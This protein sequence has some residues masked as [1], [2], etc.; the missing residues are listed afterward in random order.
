MTNSRDSRQLGWISRIDAQALD[1]QL[2]D[3]I[4]KLN[5]Y[6]VHRFLFPATTNPGPAQALRPVPDCSTSCHA[7]APCVYRAGGA[8][9][10][11]SGS[12][13]WPG[14]P[15]AK[16]PLTWLPLAQAGPHAIAAADPLPDD[17]RQV[18]EDIS[19]TSRPV[20]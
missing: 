17:L 10:E 7:S 9:C 5:A 13:P 8:A 20:H 14:V 18:L 2:H 3:A 4:L 1:T 16:R 19:N 11:A 6:P 12:W 15:P